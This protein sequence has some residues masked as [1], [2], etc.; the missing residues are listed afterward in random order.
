MALPAAPISTLMIDALLQTADKDGA[1]TQFY[2]FFFA[3]SGALGIGGAQIPKILRKYDALNVLAESPITEGGDDLTTPFGYP[4]PLKI[5]DVEKILYQLPSV[6]QIK[7]KGEKKSY[8]A[9]NGYLERSGFL[10]ALPDCNPLAASAVYEALS[11]GTADIVAPSQIEPK[12]QQLKDG[13]LLAFQSMLLQ[14]TLKRLSAYFVFA[15]LIFLVLDLIVETG[16]NA[17]L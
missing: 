6:E 11:G 5:K 3:G 2:F 16:T 14:S 12:L 8:M 10:N 9:Q 13:G 15:F 7:E 17:F 1:A 4:K